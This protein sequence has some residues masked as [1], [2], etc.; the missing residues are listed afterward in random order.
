MDVQ[1]RAI[2][3]AFRQ[4][5]E[6]KG[7]TLAEVGE[8]LG[9]DQSVLGRK[10]R[11]LLGIKPPE[12]RKWAESLGMSLDEFDERWR[13]SRVTRTVGGVGIPVI[14][15]A[16][17][18][19][20]V[21]YEEWGIDSGQG[22]EYIDWGDISDELA[23]AVIAIGDSMEPAISE[24]DYLVFTPMTIPRPRAKLEDGCVVFVRFGPDSGRDGCTVA[25]W[26]GQADG[27]IRL[28]KDN[29]RYQPLL[30]QRE[31][32]QQLS[33]CIERRTKRI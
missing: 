22:F 13:A 32:I 15:R 27:S 30:C 31:D 26:F 23:F 20:V 8:R 28:N 3:Q 18:G 29:P 7:L 4:V 12:R 11:G 21:N 17:A 25:R 10:E 5:R 1:Q 9:V 16:P 6:E 24:G 14:N 19:M 33:V 2:G